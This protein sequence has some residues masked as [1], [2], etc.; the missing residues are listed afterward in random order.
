MDVRPRDDIA[1]AVDDCLSSKIVAVHSMRTR[2]CRKWSPSVVRPDL[3]PWRFVVV[4]SS[5]LIQRADGLLFRMWV[6]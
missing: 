4:P 6:P 1:R 2:L 5:S 3:I